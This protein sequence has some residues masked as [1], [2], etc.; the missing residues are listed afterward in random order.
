MT[1]HYKRP[2]ILLKYFRQIE[3]GK[4]K[5]VFEIIFGNEKTLQG[6]SEMYYLEFIL[7]EYPTE[8]HFLLPHLFRHIL[9]RVIITYANSAHLFFHSS[10]YNII[11][12]SESGSFVTN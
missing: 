6:A 2:T 1:I 4:A 9:S 3:S 8:E 11:I 10:F 12:H 5:T 7:I